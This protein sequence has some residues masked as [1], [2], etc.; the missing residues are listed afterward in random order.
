MNSKISNNSVSN[1]IRGGQTFLHFVRMIT[2]VVKRFLTIVLSITSVMYLAILY[3]IM[4]D[5]DKELLLNYSNSWVH[6]ELLKDKEKTISVSTDDGVF[7]I[8]ARSYLSSESVIEQVEEI[9]NKVLF[10]FFLSIPPFIILIL[11]FYFVVNLMG[12][13]FIKD[14]HLRGIKV[15]DIKILR[16]EIDE[17]CSISNEKY[18][19]VTLSGVKLP[20]TFEVQNILIVGGVGTGKSVT[21]KNVLKGVRSGSKKAII[22]D[23][24]GDYVKHFYRSGVDIILN[25]MDE[26]SVSWD[27]FSE[28]THEHDF[29]FLAET[30]I[31]DSKSGDPFWTKAARIVFSEMAIIES[32]KPIPSIENLVN[33]I[34][35][36][37][38]SEMIV[39]CSST[40]ASS[41]LQKGGEKTAISIRGVLVSYIRSLKYLSDVK[42]GF[43]IKKWMNDESTDSWI[44]ITVKKDIETVLKPLITS[45][46]DIATSSILSLEPSRTRR[47]WCVFDELTTLNKLNSIKDT[48]AESRKYGGAFILSFQNY[49]QLCDVYG[50]NGADA[51]S[52]VCSTFI[53]F[54]CS[55]PNFSDWSSKQLGKADYNES[56][57]GLSFGSNEVRDG[58]N[59]GRN[60]RERAVVLSSELQSLPDL[61]CYIRL[62]RGFSVSKYVEKFIELPVV[63]KGYIENR[64][65]LDERFRTSFSDVSSDFVK[66]SVS[67]KLDLKSSFTVNKSLDKE[68]KVAAVDNADEVG[69]TVNESL[70]KNEV[71]D[72]IDNKNSVKNDIGFT[73]N[74]SL[75]KTNKQDDSL[76]KEEKEKCESDVVFS[77]EKSPEDVV[78]ISN[79]KDNNKTNKGTFFVSNRNKNKKG[80]G[81]DTENEG[82]QGILNLSKKGNTKPTIFNSNEV[83]NEVEL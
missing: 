54:R 74:N 83:D 30:L 79:V 8:Y 44:F 48:P 61:N 51:L 23:R 65:L 14:E 16:N 24:S 77:I 69:F 57:E 5:S 63:C 81:E 21:I 59:L 7:E 10:A 38:L 12:K 15:N 71:T 45:W 82:G 1:F 26:R 28:C 73:V 41:F 32:R 25:P 64:A 34:L 49:A 52:G 29:Y 42:N 53:T 67:E 70:N 56:S 18:G 43:S 9:K 50:K 22:Y 60:R 6:Y 27:V 55:E 33:D 58:V 11:L 4:T 62:G 36:M 80:D 31:P 17:F 47:I 76:V 35:K 37:D 75:D 13:K 68:N 72:G 78:D 2:Q 3:S 19:A 46:V 66:G 20:S 39:V 40:D